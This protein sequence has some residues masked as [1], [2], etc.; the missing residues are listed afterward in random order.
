MTAAPPAR[1]VR[2]D[3]G[4]NST[5]WP[6]YITKRKC[7]H[8]PR[9]MHCAQARRG[10]VYVAVLMRAFTRPVGARKPIGGAKT[11]RRLRAFAS[12]RNF[13]VSGEAEASGHTLTLPEDAVR[14]PH[15]RGPRPR[16]LPRHQ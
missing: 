11:D 4:N 12:H 9:A 2:A 1:R 15:H 14:G 10:F 13:A 5:K 3:R 6:G 16:G 8:Q 7:I